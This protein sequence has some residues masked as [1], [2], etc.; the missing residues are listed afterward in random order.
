MKVSNMDYSSATDQIK[1]TVSVT[2]ASPSLLA[3]V[4]SAATGLFNGFFSVVSGTCSSIKKITVSAK[5]LC[6]SRSSVAK[7]GLGAIALG[8]SAYLGN[9][10]CPPI[11]A[12]VARI[13]K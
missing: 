2:S 1:E 12:L 7:V 8:A 10:Y 3:R 6:A 9:K 13:K 5:D 4:K 11:Q